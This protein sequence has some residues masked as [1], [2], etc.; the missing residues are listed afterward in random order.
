[1]TRRRSPAAVRPPGRWL[2]AMAVALLRR[3]ALVPV[4]LRQVWRLAPTGWWRRSP[5]LP[6]PSAAYVGF[7]SQTMYGDADRLPDPADVCTYLHW[8]RAFPT[9]QG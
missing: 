5:Y 7:R 9:D 2:A 1:M 4:A 3:P 8:C 6:L